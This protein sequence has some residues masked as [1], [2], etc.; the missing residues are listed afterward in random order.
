MITRDKLINFALYQSAWFV[1]ILLAAGGRPIAAAAVTF[2]AVALHLALA[3]RTLVELRLVL[4]AGAIGLVVDSLNVALGLY[5]FADDGLAP[6]LAPA[7]IVAMWMLFAMTLRSCMGWI[8]SSL[9]LAAVVGLVGGPLSFLVG[10][11]FGAVTFADPRPI[12]LLVLGLAWASTLPVLSWLAE[13]EAGAHE[14]A[15]RRIR[16]R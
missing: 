5:S 15:Y 16:S 1:C 3:R 13:R 8:K 9:P 7:W 12:G 10:E 14:L 2:T 11:R 4:A 6:W